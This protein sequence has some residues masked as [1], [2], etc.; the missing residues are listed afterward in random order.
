[1][2]QKTSVV[3]TVALAYIRK[4]F[5]RDSNDM[6]SP[7]RQRAHIEAFCERKG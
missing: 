6:Q 4:S 1:M 5:T 3:R 2:P 7:K